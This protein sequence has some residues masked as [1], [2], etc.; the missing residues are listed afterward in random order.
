MILVYNN[1]NLALCDQDM[2][3]EVQKDGYAPIK[4][5]LEILT[6]CELM[7]CSFQDLNLNV[8]KENDDW[9]IKILHDED[10]KNIV[11][12]KKTKKKD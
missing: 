7:K 12:L 2:L 10:D 6:Y 8:Y 3:H 1:K 4:N 11:K 5:S 9:Y